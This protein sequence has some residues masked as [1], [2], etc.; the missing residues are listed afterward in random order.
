MPRLSINLE[1]YR[2][3]ISSSYQ[4]DASIDNILDDLRCQNV[5]V[6][7]S[8]LYGYFKQWD[9]SIRQTRALV[10]EGDFL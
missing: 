5:I 4:S 1:P 8:T 6:K 7:R 2:T 10:T 3:S 9:V